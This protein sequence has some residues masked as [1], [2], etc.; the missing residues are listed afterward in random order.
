LDSRNGKDFTNIF[1]EVADAVS[2][3]LLNRSAILD[4]EVVAYSPHSGVPDFAQLQQRFGLTATPAL[5]A[6]VPVHYLVFDVLALDGHPTVGLPY[7]QRRELLEELQL[8]HPGLSVPANHLDADPEL[9]IDIA[10]Q[11]QLEGVVGKRPD[12]AYRPGRSPDWEKHA[13]RRRIETVIGG[14]IPSNDGYGA[15]LGSLLL[16][17]P[18]PTRSTG[19]PVQVEFVGGVGTGWSGALGRRILDQLRELEQD[20]SPF[21]AALPREYSRVAHW[22]APELI[23][24][25]DYRNWTGVGYLRH[26]SFKGLRPDR[27]LAGLARGI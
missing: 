22:V 8:T 12:S 15:G 21:A 23:A 17:R 7:L 11:H 18:A 1:T 9:L 4:G 10:D 16:G 14:W 5:M 27:D 2:D 20:S 13:I 24:D 25:V 26:P 19:N 6:A 3:V